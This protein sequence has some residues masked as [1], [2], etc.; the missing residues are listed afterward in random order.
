MRRVVLTI[1]STVTGLVV[2]L[3]FKTHSTVGASAAVIG[4]ASNG[5]TPAG[6]SAASSRSSSS[7]T[8]SKTVT[9]DPADTRFGP[10]QV[11]I[12]VK[13]REITNV[14]AVEYPKNDA[15]DVQINSIAIPELNKEALA[16]QKAQIN[17]ISGATY[18]C[19]GYIS[20]LQSALDKAGL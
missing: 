15:L 12:T 11:K 8:A 17:M 1:V 6:S 3:S 13:N 19:E 9:G 16:A 14:T 7:S 10:V 18:T 5:A 20:S 2:L 4:P